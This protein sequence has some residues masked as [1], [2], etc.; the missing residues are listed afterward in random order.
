[1]VGTN[2]G[3]G[4]ESIAEEVFEHN[5]ATTHLIDTPGF[6]DITRTDADV[7]TE[8]ASFLA[9]TY[10]NHVGITGLLYIHRITDRRMS[11]SAIKNIRM[12]SKL[13]GDDA[14]ARVALATSRWNNEETDIAEEREKELHGTFFK[15]L[16]DK[17]S[18]VFR[19]DGNR[20]SG[21]QI[22]TTLSSNKSKAKSPLQLQRELMDQT[23]F[24]DE[25]EAGKELMEYF[26]KQRLQYEEK[27]RD[28]KALRETAAAEKDTQYMQALRAELTEIR[29][30]IVIMDQR[31]GRLHIDYR[32]MLKEAGQKNKQL[33]QRI[34]RERMERVIQI[35]KLESELSRLR[36]R[37]MQDL[38]GMFMITRYYWT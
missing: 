4:T 9:A 28:L 12:F 16:I 20:D 22:V 33:I 13:V 37:E 26:H 15:P 7:L 32:E 17:G 35:E 2:R 36:L 6:D 19:L 24:L 18:R 27:L 11:G 31:S 3:L 5:G 29:E 34:L 23:M 25:T 14:F 21:L 30:D 8:V 10:Q 38:E 1:M